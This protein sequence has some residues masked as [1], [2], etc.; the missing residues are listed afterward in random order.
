MF[1]NTFHRDATL[2]PHLDSLKLSALSGFVVVS[3]YS[4]LIVDK[5]YRYIKKKLRGL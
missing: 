5:E 4:I 2:K 1:D 3:L